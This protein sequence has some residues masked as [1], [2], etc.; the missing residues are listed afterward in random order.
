MS[1]LLDKWIPILAGEPRMN[2][3]PRNATNTGYLLIVKIN[4]KKIYIKKREKKK[5]RHLVN[6]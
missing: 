2:G 3:H 4:I 1:Y 6:I 5:E